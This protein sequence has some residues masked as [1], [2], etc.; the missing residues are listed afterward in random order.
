[1]EL[2]FK[3]LGFDVSGWLASGGIIVLAG[4]IV[5]FLR[6]KGWIMFVNQAAVIGAKVSRALSE[7]LDDTADTFEA[8]DKAIDENG[9]LVEKNVK[10]VI[11]KG[12]QAIIEWEDVVM[13]IKP[14]KKLPPG[15]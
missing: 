4:M 13:V 9:K 7:A 5:T 12:K 10:D 15:N 14:K 2:L 3:L 6:K 8:V 11:A 1:M